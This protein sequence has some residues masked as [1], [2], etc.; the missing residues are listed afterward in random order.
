MREGMTIRNFKTMQDD[1][2][3]RAKHAEYI[4]EQ[5]SFLRGGIEGVLGSYVMRAAEFGDGIIAH[6]HSPFQVMITLIIKRNREKINEIRFS[7]R[8]NSY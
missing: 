3:E 6:E 4:D 5:I 1:N 8:H 2:Q 7:A